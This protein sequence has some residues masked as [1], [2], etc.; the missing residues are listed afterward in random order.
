MRVLAR[1]SSSAVTPLLTMSA[2]T[3]SSAVSAVLK[4]TPGCGTAQT[5]NRGGGGESPLLRGARMGGHPLVAHQR[6]V[7]PA[8]RAAAEN[9]RQHLERLGIL[10]RRRVG[11]NQT[12][13]RPERLGDAVRGQGDRA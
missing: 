11:G 9:M 3:S 13:P 7:E 2:M 8:G 6:P 12:A 5:P 10:L 1:S 4:V